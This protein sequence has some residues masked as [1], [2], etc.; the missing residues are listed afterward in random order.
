MSNDRITLI[1][2][3]TDNIHHLNRDYKMQLLKLL[4]DVKTPIKQIGTGC[5]INFENIDNES[6]L[7]VFKIVEMATNQ[8]VLFS[9]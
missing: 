8:P 9:A 3:I 2:Y 5:V 1:D 6:L 4:I 7:E